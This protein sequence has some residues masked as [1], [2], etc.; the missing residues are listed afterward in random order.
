MAPV[1]VSPLCIYG[2]KTTEQ[3]LLLI[4]KY[5]FLC[6]DIFSLMWQTVIYCKKQ[7]KMLVVFS[8]IF[9]A[10]TKVICIYSFV[11]PLNL[12]RQF[13]HSRYLCTRAHIWIKENYL[14]GLSMITSI[15]RSS[16]LNIVVFRCCFISPS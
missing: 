10:D 2:C 12:L 15:T 5:S 14:K 13:V 6:I 9:V 16:E 11:T 8:S 1:C 4:E 7:F 3:M